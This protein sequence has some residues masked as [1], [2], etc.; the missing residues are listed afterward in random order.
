MGNCPFW[1]TKTAKISC[2]IECP[3]SVT[4][5]VCAFKEVAVDADFKIKDIIEDDFGFEDSKV[6]GI[7]DYI[8]ESSY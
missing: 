4:Q 8:V 1:S 7:K 3:M 6:L 2:N 5:E